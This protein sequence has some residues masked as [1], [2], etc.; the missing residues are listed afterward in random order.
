MPILNHEL[1]V[2]GVAQIINKVTGNHIF[3]EQDVEVCIQ[4]YKVMHL[5]FSYIVPSPSITFG[6]QVLFNPHTQST[7][8]VYRSCRKKI[9]TQIFF[10][11][12]F[13][14]FGKIFLDFPG[15]KAIDGAYIC[16]L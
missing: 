10:P 16:E 15:K 14:F 3:E 2:I 13:F 1:E 5:V 12:F 6:V 7:K 4:H 8:H 11:F 9:Y